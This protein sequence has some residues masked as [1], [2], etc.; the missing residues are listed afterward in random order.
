VIPQLTCKI[1]YAQGW[2][3]EP[4]CGP[5]SHV[6]HRVAQLKQTFCLK[7]CPV[8]NESKHRS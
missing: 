1:L 7:H 3:D 2:C 8:C 5:I 6:C 4:T